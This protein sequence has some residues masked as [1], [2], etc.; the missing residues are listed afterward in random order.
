MNALLS[1]LMKS[2]GGVL[3]ESVEA[4]IGGVLVRRTMQRIA[5]ATVIYAIVGVLSLAALIFLYVFSYLWLAAR[6]DGQ[7]A[8]AI[9]FGAN[10]LLIALVL[11]GK[12]VSGRQRQPPARPAGILDGL[13]EG[14]PLLD[15][16]SLE[17]GMA[18]GS[19]IG[20]RL[21][22]AAPEI[23]LVAGIV[24]LII[25]ARPEILN[26]FGGIARGGKDES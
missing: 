23:A 16:E 24:G 15:P 14:K 21:R 17:A 3:L 18:L 12:W 6:L 10:L 2:G 26:L 25:G 1:F 11:L 20:N 5:R 9:L 22:K 4:Y 19:E 8:A 7:R 13:R